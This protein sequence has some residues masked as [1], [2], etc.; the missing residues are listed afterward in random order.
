M[1]VGKVQ[2]SGYVSHLAS[3]EEESRRHLVEADGNES[4]SSAEIYVTNSGGVNGI[5][6]KRYGADD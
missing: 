1:N 4:D 2:P 6:S 3:E 5:N